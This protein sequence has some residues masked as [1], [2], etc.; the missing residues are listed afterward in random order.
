[1]TA[2]ANLIFFVSDNH[3]ARAVGCYGN[4]VV[5][6]P[7][8]DR[9]ARGG[10]CFLNSYATTAICCGTENGGWTLG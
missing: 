10:M 5:L 7:N 3:S 2:S 8:I 4:P 1:M 6:T 9:I